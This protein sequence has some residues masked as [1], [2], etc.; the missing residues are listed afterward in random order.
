MIFGNETLAD[1]FP[2]G[3]TFLAPGVRAEIG[4]RIEESR[5][6]RTDFLGTVAGTVVAID[7]AP[8][9]PVG[10]PVPVAVRIGAPLIGTF[11]I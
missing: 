8:V 10:G 3:L 4:A 1:T 6:A 9:P 2:R 7:A 5:R 11:P